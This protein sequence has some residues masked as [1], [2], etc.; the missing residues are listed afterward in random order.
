MEHL[1]F[2]KRRA[3]TSD[4]RAGLGKRA[5]CRRLGVRSSTSNRESIHEEIAEGAK[6][7]VAQVENCTRTSAGTRIG[8]PVCALIGHHRVRAFDKS[9][10]SKLRLISVKRSNVSRVAL[11]THVR[12]TILSSS[13]AGILKSISCRRTTQPIVFCASELA[14]ASQC[15]VATSWT[16]RRYT[17]LFT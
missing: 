6:S 1:R 9:C 11:P 8:R 10:P 12:N 13:A 17:V 16:H 15:A 3:I 5:Q 7:F 2:Q 4:D 14:T